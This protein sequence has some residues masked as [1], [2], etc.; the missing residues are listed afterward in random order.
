[1]PDENLTAKAKE[2]ACSFAIVA[3]VELGEGNERDYDLEA[4]YYPEAELLLTN[5]PQ[6]FQWVEDLEAVLR[7][8]LEIAGDRADKLHAARRLQVSLMRQDVYKS[9]NEGN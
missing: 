3:K 7:E 4:G 6:K 9:R 2:L 8:S 1:M 5:K